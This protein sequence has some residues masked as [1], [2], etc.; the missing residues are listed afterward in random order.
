MNIRSVLRTIGF[1]L[2][3][4]AAS[5]LLSV[6]VAL[7]Y[8]DGDASG[9]LIATLVT[10]VVA[11]TS[12]YLNRQHRELDVKEGFAIVTFSWILMSVAG[13]LPYL[14]TGSIPDLTNAFFESASGF[15]TTGAT[16]LADVE[17]LPHGVLFWRSFTHWIGGMGIVVLSIAILPFLGVGGM[18]LF[19][20]EAPG[21][22]T[23]KLTPRIRDTASLLWG[24]YAGL[25]LLETLLLM[26]GG[27]D[28]FD[29]V[30]HSF[31]TLATGGFST[32][33]TS[34]AYFQ[35]PYIEWV[36]IIFMYLA[37]INFTLHYNAL[38]GKLNSY[39]KSSE[40]RF[41]SG[42]MLFVVAIIV[43]VRLMREDTGFM[44]V[45][46]ESMF[47]AL[48]VGTAT[49]FANSDFELWPLVTQILLVSLMVMGGM[50]GSTAGGM[51]SMR[52]H[53]LMQQARL[54]LYHLIHPHAIYKIRQDNKV[55]PDDVVHNILVFFFVYIL[56]MTI[57]TVLL[58]FLDIDPVTGI[59][60]SI[61]CLSNVGP[62]LGRVGPLDNYSQL[63]NAAKW[64]LTFMMIA[65]RLEFFT[66]L[67]LFTRKYWEKS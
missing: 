51:K 53:V 15:T 19:K 20:T 45:I 54:D 27:M 10:A 7:I 35:S 32:K 65:G 34:I 33:N 5:M 50:A 1:I 6:G 31:A 36:V 9:I 62:G 25:T 66:V 12:I 16:I 17:S 46:R 24:I 55:I 37:G 29:A 39:W 40:F 60:A 11:I 48:S 49:G 22:T 47:S 4:V 2:L 67:V 57:S 28:W 43:I 59:T 56:M 26:F 23:D 13:M 58:A 44:A 52:V 3:F 30:T 42:S 38:R 61:A 8:G 64:I 14:F 63:P 41:F 21:P 18:Q